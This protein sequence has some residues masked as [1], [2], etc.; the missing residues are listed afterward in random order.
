METSASGVGLNSASPRSAHRLHRKFS[1]LSFRLWLQIT[2]RLGS[3]WSNRQNNFIQRMSKSGCPCFLKFLGCNLNQLNCFPCSFI[4]VDVTC[5]NRSGGR[6]DR[7]PCLR[8]AYSRE[9]GVPASVVSRKRT[10]SFRWHE[11]QGPRIFSYKSTSCPQ[12]RQK[13]AVLP[14]RPAA[15]RRS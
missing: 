7:V 14:R 13:I 4:S 2:S 15:P 3:L 11:M 8:V 6:A 10:Y 5:E 9:S 1:Q 12:C